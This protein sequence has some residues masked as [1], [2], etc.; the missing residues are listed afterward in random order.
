[1]VLFFIKGQAELQREKGERGRERR[2][3]ES[4][5]RNFDKVIG[6]YVG[7]WKNGAMHGN[8][9]WTQPDGNFFFFKIIY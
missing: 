9:V 5:L 1:M 6:K 8:G 4:D 3:G 7:K 2:R